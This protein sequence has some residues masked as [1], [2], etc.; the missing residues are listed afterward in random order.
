[1]LAALLLSVVAVDTS[2]AIA[3]PPTIRSML[4][5]AMASG[6]ENAVN[7]IVKYARVADPASGDASLKLASDWKDARARERN[8]RLRE[9]S[10]FELWTGRVEA[11]G[12]ASTGNTQVTGI[13]AAANLQRESLNW[14]QKLRLQA[15]YQRNAGVTSREHYLAAYEPNWKIDDRLYLYGSAQFEADRFL[16]YYERYSASAG[17]GYNALR[18]PRLTLDIELGPAFR[19]TSFTDGRLQSSPA[20]R[21]SLDMNLRLSSGVTVKQNASAY[22]ERFNS[23][24]SS[25]TAVAAKLIGPLSAQVSYTVQ[26]ESSPPEGRVSTDTTSRASLVYS[27]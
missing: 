10:A 2:D 8:E 13:T 23:T 16:G 12:F 7:T 4:D 3:I 14:R 6:D 22:A 24:V 20:A 25:N 19:Y 1:M 15:D 11:G 18:S 26:Y 27:F 17:A 9:A 21:G 5:A